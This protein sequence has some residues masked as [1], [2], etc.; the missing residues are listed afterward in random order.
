MHT[1]SGYVLHEGPIDI[2]LWSTAVNEM[3]VMF[4][5][6]NRVNNLNYTHQGV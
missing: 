5:F 6:D 2:I 1:Q 4:L 3:A